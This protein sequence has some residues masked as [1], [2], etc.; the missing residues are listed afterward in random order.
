MQSNNTEIISFDIFDTLLIRN[1]IKPTDVFRLIG[2][3]RHDFSF[4]YRRVLAEKI[5]RKIHAKKTS[6]DD[7]YAFPF[8]TKNERKLELR[9][10]EFVLEVN[11]KI[12]N[13]YQNFIKYTESVFAISDMY[14][15]SVFIK[16]VLNREGFSSFKKV[17]ISCEYG[18]EKSD[19]SLFDFFLKENEYDPNKVTHYGDN[20]IADIKM[21]KNAGI[22][23]VHITRDENNLRK[24]I[25]K[26]WER[27]VEGFLNH[28]ISYLI[29]EYEKIGYEFLG[30]YMF[31]YPNLDYLSVKKKIKLN[32]VLHSENHQAIKF[33]IGIE[34]CIDDIYASKWKHFIHQN[35]KRL[36][37]KKVNYFL[38]TFEQKI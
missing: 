1:L 35:S 8:L 6:F 34:K 19:G 25:A 2:E 24:S 13:A 37:L 28:K 27:I 32:K 9:I 20:L 14:L 36:A 12:F 31:L 15:P 21:A 30:L 4:I 29:D 33:K 38:K 11:P 26:G 23:T 22:H 3:I 16:K 17:Y 5:A 10:E 7:I 18:L